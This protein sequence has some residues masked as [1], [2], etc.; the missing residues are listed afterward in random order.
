MKGSAKATSQ[1]VSPC[2]PHLREYSVVEENAIY[3]AA[4]YVIRRMLKKFKMTDDDKG[5]AITSTL[6]TMIG[7]DAESIEATSTYLDY[8]KTWTTKTDRGGLIHVSN[9]CFRFFCAVEQVTYEKLEKGSSK[10]E[11]ITELMEH[12]T[13]R[14]YWD[15]I[16]GELENDWSDQLLNDIATLWFTIRGFTV[17]GRLLEEYKAGKKKNIKGSKGL[18]KELH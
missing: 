8:V 12:G 16:V 4:G 17:T 3:Y 18:R 1:S 14:F 9:D 11:F 15:I 5:A 13:V 10:A 6:L 7:E 2:E